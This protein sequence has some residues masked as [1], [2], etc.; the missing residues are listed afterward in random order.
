[1]TSAMSGTNTSRAPADARVCTDR[2]YPA[3]LF[4]CSESEKT[5][6]CVNPWLLVC[7]LLV[8]NP[9]RLKSKLIGHLQCTTV[10]C[11]AD[12]WAESL[13]WPHYCAWSHHCQRQQWEDLEFVC[14]LSCDGWIQS[15]GMQ[16]APAIFKRLNITYCIY[17]MWSQNGT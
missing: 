9:V 6:M 5:K 2:S 15:F 7:A 17:M 14:T 4:A 13:V 1:M 3:Y 8:M 12:H 10:S 16:S 11:K